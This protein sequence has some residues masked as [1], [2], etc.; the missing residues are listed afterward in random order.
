MNSVDSLEMVHLN[1]GKIVITE[2]P[3]IVRTVLGSCVSVVMFV[4]SNGLAMISHSIYPG[5]GEEGDL[6][7]TVNSINRM[8]R[9]IKRYNTTPRNVT[10][11]LFGGGLQLTN[12]EKKVTQDLQSNNV[13]NAIDQL[14][15]H[16]YRVEASSV[17]GNYSREIRFY[18]NSGTVLL[19]RSAISHPEKV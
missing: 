17:G 2:E 14:K 3:V 9:E 13:Q 16:G 7:Y 5:S 6:R 10:V 18:T 15:H 11:K 19:K 8:D 1:I 12:S 4:S